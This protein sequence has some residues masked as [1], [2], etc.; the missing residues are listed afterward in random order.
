V[1]GEVKFIVTKDFN[2]RFNVEFNAFPR[3]SQLERMDISRQ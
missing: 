2:K 3:L 1:S